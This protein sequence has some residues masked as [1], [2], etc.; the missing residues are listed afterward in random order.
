MIVVVGRVVAIKV[1]G[2]LIEWVIVDIESVG[3]I[4]EDIGCVGVHRVVIFVAVVI[5][6]MVP[7]VLI[8]RVV[9]MA[10]EIV[11]LLIFLLLLGLLS[12]LLSRL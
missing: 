11:L 5:V 1:I 2:V 8:M 6:V 12:V 9:V 3:D 7:V 4:V 10:V